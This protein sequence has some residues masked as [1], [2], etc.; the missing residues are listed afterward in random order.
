M[1]HR[2]GKKRC[3]T[4]TK[5]SEGKWHTTKAKGANRQHKGT[6]KGKRS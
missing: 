2:H 3:I 5:G 4:R 6:G 1:T